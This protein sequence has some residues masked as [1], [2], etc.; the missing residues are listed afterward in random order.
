[1]FF[2]LH[3]IFILRQNNYKVKRKISITERQKCFLS[4]LGVTIIIINLPTTGGIKNISGSVIY[5]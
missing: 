5:I 2:Y 4:K 1:M 3:L